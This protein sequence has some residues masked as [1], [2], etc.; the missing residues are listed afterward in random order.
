MNVICD[1]CNKKIK[2]P[3]E[4]I[5][6]GKAFSISCPKCKNKISVKAK[7]AKTSAPE[8]KRRD[9]SVQAPPP[10]KPHTKRPTKEEESNGPPLNPFEF[11]EE[12]AKTAIVCEPSDEIAQKLKRILENM[13]Y[14]VLIANNPRETLKQM[15]FHEFDMVIINELFGTRDPDMNHVLKF[16]SQ[17]N[18]TSRRNMFVAL[19][20]NRFRTADNMQAFNKSVNLIINPKDM[21]KFEQVLNRGIT[22]NENF[23]KVFKETYARIKGY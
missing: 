3:D 10:S 9:S 16:L 8:K 18:M 23:Y 4:K 17:L 22:E 1:N 5:P 13:D 15:R 2:I 7:P 6:K 20:S 21:D 12:G 19:I 14:H 11:L